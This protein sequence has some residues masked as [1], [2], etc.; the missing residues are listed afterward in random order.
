MVWSW[1]RGDGNDY[2]AAG[3]E[4]TPGSDDP[5]AAYDAREG[6]YTSA[7]PLLLGAEKA[8]TDHLSKGKA[9]SASFEHVGTAGSG[10]SRDGEGSGSDTSAFGAT[11][12]SRGSDDMPIATAEGDDMQSLG[13]RRRR[14]VVWP[15]VGDESK[16]PS[17]SQARRFYPYLLPLVLLQFACLTAPIVAL[18]EG[19]DGK[20]GGRFIG[21]LGAMPY[22]ASVAAFVAVV[23]FSSM[24]YLYHYVR[25]SGSEAAPELPAAGVGGAHPL[26]HVVIVCSYKEP[27][28]V[29]E[30]TFQSI[31]AQRGISKAPIAVLAAEER[32]ETRHASF[33]MLQKQCEGRLG[34]LLLTEHELDEGEAAGKGSNE[35]WAAREVY[36][37][38]VFDEGLDP[39]E[40][41]VTIVDADS[42]LSLTYLAHVE[43]AYH[44]EPDGR[45]L[46]YKGPLNVYRNF[47]DAGLFVQTLELARCHADTFHGPLTVPYPYSNYSL[48]LGFAAEIG[49]WTPDCMPEDIHTANKAM[50]NS[51]GSRATV[52]IPAV[53]CNDLVP[54]VSDRYM[55]A[56]RH[57]WGSVTEFA[58]LLALLRDT[59]IR[60]PAWWAV[61]SSE[62][63]RAGSLAGACACLAGHVL[64]AV[65]LIALHGHWQE[66][67]PRA[68][69]S[70]SL[71]GASAVLQW[72]LFWV[73]ELAYWNSLLRQFPIERP[74]VCRWVLLV[75][76]MPVANVF[77]SVLF[78]V[79][80]TFH[81]LYHAA[82]K[83][84]LAYVC[85][86]KGDAA[87]GCAPLLAAV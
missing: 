73:A 37:R 18:L 84:E 49:F 53:I 87:R 80:P 61:F 32:D 44:S 65:V 69:F 78:F 23:F 29:L 85:A 21:F 4:Y 41:V 42:I 40:V 54:M 38:L 66:L 71:M 14:S 12:S 33:A 5:E 59:K 68:A 55:Q 6:S 86:P 79:V 16:L 64:Q 13:P 75:V 77:N 76:A 8:A 81:A 57:Q 45:R 34:R 67:P 24:T 27:V 52:A 39:F 48:A 58:W 22:W 7:A 43:A 2:E 74:S 62:M 10:S 46:I 56:K 1:P 28:E 9:S 47:A 82:F 19:D 50:V 11:W 20:L 63:A 17:Q 30:R 15:R 51:F 83:G 31:A 35:N 60:L 72:L 36:K 25:F 70:L 3:D 26:T